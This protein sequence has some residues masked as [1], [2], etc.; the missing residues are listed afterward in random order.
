[1]VM[2]PDRTTHSSLLYDRDF[3]QWTQVM[4][5][6]LRSRNWAGLDIENVC[7]TFEL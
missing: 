4:A 6:A 2:T 7:E 3:H 1:M 5:E